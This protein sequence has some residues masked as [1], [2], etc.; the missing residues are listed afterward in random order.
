MSDADTGDSAESKERSSDDCG[1][2]G[3]GDGGVIEG[4]SGTSQRSGPTNT[5]RG[6]VL[7][8]LTRT[9]WDRVESIKVR[10]LKKIKDHPCIKL[11]DGSERARGV[12]SGGRGKER[13][14]LHDRKGAGEV[15]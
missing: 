2:W 1:H 14:R 12:L 4:G 3:T 8:D 13:R 5:G 10:V 6:W 11:C 15:R 9:E 7:S